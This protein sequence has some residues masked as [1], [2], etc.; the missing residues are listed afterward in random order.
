MWR[1]LIQNKEWLFS[2]AG[3]AALSLVWW[4]LSKARTAKRESLI[5]VAGTIA[6]SPVTLAPVII[7]PTFNNNSPQEPG[8]RRTPSPPTPEAG[9]VAQPNLKVEAIKIAKLYLEEGVWTLN[10][11]KGTSYRGLLVDV[12]NVPIA[13]GKLKTVNIKASVTIGSRNYSPLP[14]LGEF[15]NT[16]KLG[17]ASRKSLVM[18]IGNDE[19]LG[20]WYFVLN[21]RERYTQSEIPMDWTNMAP[22]PA[23]LAEILLVDVDSGE[24]VAKFEYV[25]KF[26]I[27]L[28]FP[29][30]R[31]FSE[32]KQT[33]PWDL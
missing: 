11:Q 25:W 24:S 30:L 3:L 10:Q 2:G 32:M 29:D 9:P 31:T 7:S 15:T 8:E 16:V 14:W 5:P 19:P 12:A 22:L 1:W 28:G 21:H 6:Q 13:S 23:H 18:A 27:T 20:P 4:L 33:K 17:P 26:D